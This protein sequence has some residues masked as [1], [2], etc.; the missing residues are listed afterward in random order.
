[1]GRCYVC[2]DTDEFTRNCNY[3]G[4][5]TCSRHTLPE[6]HDCLALDASDQ[7]IVDDTAAT[8]REASSSERDRQTIGATEA[9][10]TADQPTVGSSKQSD[11]DSSP[12]VALDGS[13]QNETTVGGNSPK[14]Q[15][16]HFSVEVL[17]LRAKT[18]GYTAIQLSGFGVLFYGAHQMVQ[19]VFRLQGYDIS[20]PS[21]LSSII[22]ALDMFD[23]MLAIV[24]GLILVW[25]TT[26]SW[27]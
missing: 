25:L 9:E 20:L 18:L 14:T 17:G 12:D 10:S 16:R 26:A 7:P 5:E 4:R 23:S 8:R 11:I 21:A 2:G 27:F 22:P 24:A 19:P 6:K 15:R 13:I 1:M 3:C